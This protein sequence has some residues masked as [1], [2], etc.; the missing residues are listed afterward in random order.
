MRRAFCVILFAATGAACRSIGTEVVIP[1]KPTPAAFDG[2][3]GGRSVAQ[4]SWRDWFGDAQLNGLIA[5]ALSNNQDLQIAMQRIE[6][7]RAGARG[8]SGL[9]L[10]QVALSLGSSLQRFGLYTS[11]GASNATTEITPGRPIPNPLP[12]FAVG[13]QASWEVDIWGKLR[14]QRESAVAQYLATIEGTNLVITSLVSDVASTYFELLAL[15]HLREVL[16]QSVARQQEAL[17]VVRLQKAAGRANELAVQQFEAQLAQT[18]ALELAST[19][20]TLETENRINLL[21]G[22]YPRP[23]ARNK[24]VLFTELPA[25]AAAGLPS[26]LLRN[27]PDIREAELQV[28]ASKFDLKAARAAFFPS[29]NL[30][31]SVGFEAFNPTLLFRVP[32]SLTYSVAG[33]LLA[34]LVNRRALEAQFAGAKASQIQ[35]MYGYQRTILV[36]YVEVVN[37]LSSIRHTE[38]I[39]AFKKAQKAATVQAVSAADMLF[40][41]GKASYLEVLLAQQSALRA[42]L[43]LIDTWKRRR[44]ANVVVYKALGGGG[45]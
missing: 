23:I 18:Q 20:E 19:R 3:S 13:L 28:R 40:R 43:D 36:A 29:I 27:R 30:S 24:D 14:N 44:I 17:E 12:D 25:K 1:D 38:Q 11:E 4:T 21:L 42:D 10:P 5:E 33:G 37:A 34:P 41:A 8:A 32:G 22:R 31:A 7:A 2:E 15:D 16:R 39:L 9:L 35:A 45:R 26:E 6:M